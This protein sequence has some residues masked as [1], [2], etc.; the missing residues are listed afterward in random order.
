[1]FAVTFVNT[2]KSRKV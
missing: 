2:Q 1:M